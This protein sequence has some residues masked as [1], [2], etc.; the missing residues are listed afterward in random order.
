MCKDLLSSQSDPALSYRLTQGYAW[1]IA[2]LMSTPYLLFAGVA[3]FII[4][5]ARH[6]R[7]KV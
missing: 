6:R 2:L 7:A 5:S 1:S 4:R 3:F